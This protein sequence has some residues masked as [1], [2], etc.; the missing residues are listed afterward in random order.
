MSSWNQEGCCLTLDLKSARHLNSGESL[1][2][3]LTYAP[4]PNLAPWSS[5]D[6]ALG[7]SPS[8][9]N[10]ARQKRP[11]TL[12]RKPCL[13]SSGLLNCQFSIPELIWNYLKLGSF[14]KIALAFP[15]AAYLGSF[16]KTT[17][18]QM[19]SFRKIPAR[20]IPCFSNSLSLTRAPGLGFPKIF[21][22]RKPRTARHHFRRT[23]SRGS[24]EPSSPPAG[25][26]WQ[27]T[28]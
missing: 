4:V 14:R 5:A 18:P 24:G 28:K 15:H 7:H 27:P 9:Q 23:S 8:A 2:M 26:L 16:C 19:A 21:P 3:L 10:E 12:Q 17:P 13:L 11:K 25:R 22:T 6:I 20:P 1:L